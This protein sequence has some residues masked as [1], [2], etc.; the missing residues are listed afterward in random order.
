MP[1]ILTALIVRLENEH[2]GNIDQYRVTREVPLP[3]S[4]DD[5][6]AES[7]GDDDEDA[8]SNMHKR[9]TSRSWRVPT[10]GPEDDATAAEAG[11]VD[12]D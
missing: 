3:Y 1:N 2:L 8:P 5:A 4:Y 11:A 7:D 10:K 6:N 12:E 9:T